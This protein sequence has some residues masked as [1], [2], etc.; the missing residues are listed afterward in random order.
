VDSSTLEKVLFI[1]T[2]SKL[3]FHFVGKVIIYFY[4]F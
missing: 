2:H 1:Y 3:Y 4:L